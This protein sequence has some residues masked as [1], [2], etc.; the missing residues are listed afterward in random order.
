MVVFLHLVSLYPWSQ[1]PI[2]Q[3]SL[4]LFQFLGNLRELGVPSCLSVLGQLDVKGPVLAFWKWLSYT[5]H[6]LSDKNFYSGPT[7]ILKSEQQQR[8]P[9]ASSS[10]KSL[11]RTHALRGR[12]FRSRSLSSSQK[13]KIRARGLS[14][15]FSSQKMGLRVCGRS[16]LLV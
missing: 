5:E 6:W 7:T 9:G 8:L 10:G 16:A 4:F 13:T 15:I 1:L 11:P 2:S 3:N 14:A 12:E